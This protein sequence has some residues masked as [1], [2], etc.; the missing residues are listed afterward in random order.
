MVSHPVIGW[1]QPPSGW[2]ARGRLP[3]ALGVVAFAL[4]ARLAIPLPV[5]AQATSPGCAL[6][7]N[8]GTSQATG[9][10]LTGLGGAV[11]FAAG[12]QLQV[13]AGPPENPSFGTPVGPME[14]LLNDTAV[15]SGAYPGTLTYTIPT[16]GLY[17]VL[18]RI[19]Q[20]AVTWQFGCT[21]APPPADLA[22]T[23]T[24]L[25][26]PMV[27]GTDLTYTIVVTTAG[28]GAAQTVQLSDTLPAN[29]TFVSFTTPAGWT[30]STPAVGATGTVSATRAALPADAGPQTFTLVVRVAATNAGTT[31]SNTATVAA[32]NDL[33][34]TNNTATST[35][36]VVPP[37]TTPPTI[38][39][40]ASPNQLWPPNHRLVPV[41]VTVTATDA[42]G[43]PTVTLVS[44]TSSEP[45]NGL[46]DGDTAGDIQ[47]WLTGTDDRTG[48]LRAERGG[49]GPGRVYTLTY[50]ATDQAG[51]TTTAICAVTV[52]HN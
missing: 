34:P 2:F 25:P 13:T 24:D 5:A 37:D 51:N 9:V 31:L 52:P 23:K 16:G 4:V 40:R 36:Q 21:P 39:C 1:H 28:P 22:I 41:T 7:N 19:T 47:G 30:P 11:M 8:H 6:L 15:A 50:R 3:V 49:G 38:G 29:T 12:D 42:S 27:A 46:G 26:D 32:S 33:T 44:V 18:V 17:T 10:N 20:G 43:T 48:Q 35:T 45:D 14:L